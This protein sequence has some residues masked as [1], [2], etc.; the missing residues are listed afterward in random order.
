MPLQFGEPAMA[1]FVEPDKQA[2]TLRERAQ[3]ETAIVIDVSRD[4][5]ND[6]AGQPQNL[7]RRTGDVDDDVRVW[8]TRK[9]HRIQHAVTVEVGRNRCAR[10]ARC[11]AERRHEGPDPSD[12]HLSISVHRDVLIVV[13]NLPA[14]NVV[15]SPV[16]FGP[17]LWVAGAG[18]GRGAEARQT[19]D[20][21]AAL[22]AA[23]FPEKMGAIL[24]GI[25]AG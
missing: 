19:C 21:D 2:P 9:N 16:V 17:Q 20:P 14:R 6:P 25:A 23:Q 15:F 8:G 11:Q 1:G 7:R 5:R 13:H 3:I 18:G 12:H 4:D 10:G 24:N 22:R